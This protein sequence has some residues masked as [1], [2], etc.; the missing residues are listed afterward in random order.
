MGDQEGWGRGWF[1]ISL[2]CCDWLDALPLL[3]TDWQ[4]GITNPLR[5][6]QDEL[7]QLIPTQAVSGRAG[8]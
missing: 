6:E 5:Y 2:M 8:I 1:S 7:S 3:N 4:Q